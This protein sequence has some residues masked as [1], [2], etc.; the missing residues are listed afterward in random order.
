VD[1]LVSFGGDGTLL[2]GARL[3]AQHHT[4]VLGV[5]LGHLGFLTSVA[6]QE[7]D[8]AFAAFFARVKTYMVS[9]ERKDKLDKHPHVDAYRKAKSATGLARPDF[10]DW[11]DEGPK[12]VEFRKPDLVIV[13]MGGNDGQDIPPW[14][15]SDR[16]RW[17][18]DEW[19]AAYRGRG[20]PFV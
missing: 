12:Q 20:D 6:P 8:K 1:L 7:L 5:N 16:V 17:D 11:Y 10:F 14:K 19:P 2:R 3:V 9:N 4:P 13:V 15:G 18:S